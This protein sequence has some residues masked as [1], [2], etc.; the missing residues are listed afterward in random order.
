M[1]KVLKTFGV[2]F[3]I[4][5]VIAAIPAIGHLLAFGMLVIKLVV[6][7]VFALVLLFVGVWLLRR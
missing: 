7:V 4:L 5:A 1:T 3:L 2:L 6:E